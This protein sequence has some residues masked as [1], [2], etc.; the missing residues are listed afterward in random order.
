MTSLPG[1]L[2]AIKP[3]IRKMKYISEYYN[4]L[5]VVVQQNY[6]GD[7]EYVGSFTNNKSLSKLEAWEL[8]QNSGCLQIR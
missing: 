1:V 2:E 3:G 8:K 7:L 4:L 5:V 6:I